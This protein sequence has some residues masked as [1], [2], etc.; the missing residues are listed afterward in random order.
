MDRDHRSGA[1]SRFQVDEVP[2]C[3]L[4]KVHSVDE[5]EI[6]RLPI[7]DCPEVMAGEELVARDLEDPR[8]VGNGV[9][10]LRGRI[11]SDAERPRTC[12]RE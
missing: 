10:Q 7:E 8:A 6:D 9:M 1:R 5:G 12:L 3:E 4:E 2:Q 11:D